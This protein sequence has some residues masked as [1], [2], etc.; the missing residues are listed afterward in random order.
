ML[1]IFHLQWIK[2]EM[3]REC[4]SIFYQI[5]V[6]TEESSIDGCHCKAELHLLVHLSRW[7]CCCCCWGCFYCHCWLW[8]CGLCSLGRGSGWCGWC[9]QLTFLIQVIIQHC[10]H[11][12]KVSLTQ[13][14]LQH[15]TTMSITSY[16][17][18]KC[19]KL[20]PVANHIYSYLI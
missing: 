13:R 10:H 17:Q 14:H 5:A 6:S 4:I 9:W 1:C 19:I 7:R 18:I 11:H 3:V 15:Q 12:C 20:F 8:R 2:I 16:L